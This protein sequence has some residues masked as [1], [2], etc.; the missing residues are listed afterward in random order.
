MTY[1]YPEIGNLI[2]IDLAIIIQGII[3]NEC[4]QR[5]IC[6]PIVDHKWLEIYGKSHQAWHTVCAYKTIE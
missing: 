3:R 1:N 2:K 5:E 4:N 6:C